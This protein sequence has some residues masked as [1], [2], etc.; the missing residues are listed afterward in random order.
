MIFTD[1]SKGN[2]VP[3]VI[4]GT[5]CVLYGSSIYLFLPLGMLTQDIGMVL[6]VF[7]MILLGMILGLT[8]YV[9]NLQG[10]LEIAFVYIF[11][12]WERQSTR[13]LILKNLASHKP[14]NFLTSI[15]YSLTLGCIIFLLV[16][17]SLQI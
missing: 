8:L 10:I 13:Q 1:N 15:I 6:T 16:T 11:L 9:S 3:F 2:I 12:V 5:I 14:R 4:F 7:L 17:A